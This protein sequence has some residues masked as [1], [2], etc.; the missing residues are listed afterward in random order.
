MPF[1]RRSVGTGDRGKLLRALK[2]RCDALHTRFDVYALR[3][4]DYRGFT[5]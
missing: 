2:P 4:E 5:D 3:N 1:F